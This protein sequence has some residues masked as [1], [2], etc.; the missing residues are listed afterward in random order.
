MNNDIEKDLFETNPKEVV[1]TTEEIIVETECECSDCSCCEGCTEEVEAP[2]KKFKVV[3]PIIIAAAAFLL[4]AVL[5]F[6][7]VWVYDAF[8]GTSIKGIWI[9]KGYE[10]S[11]VYFEFDSNGNAYL[12]GGGISYY[13]NY[14]TE[15]FNVDEDKQLPEIIEKISAVE[16]LSGNVNVLTSE[17][18]LFGM[19]GGQYV[20]TVGKEDGNKTITLKYVDAAGAIA[21]WTLVNTKLPDFKIDPA[22]VTNA[23]ADEAGINTLVTDKNIIGSWSEADFGTYTFYADGTANY[24]TDY[25]VDQTYAMF[26]GVTMGYGADLNFK[27]TVGDGKIYMTVD[28]FTGEGKD[29]TMSYYLDGKNLVIDGV[30]YAKVEG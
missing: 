25:R 4:A 1:E 11:G 5:V 10:D 3:T 17:F 21:E 27:Y 12:R 18:Y 8:F 19:Y 20:Y 22:V 29:G 23:S 26:Y 2:K 6:G 9:E 28:Y 15:T 14:E 30:G 13:G 24:K 16:P 7:G